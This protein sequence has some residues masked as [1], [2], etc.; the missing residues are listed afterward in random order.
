MM[1]VSEEIEVPKIPSISECGVCPATSITHPARAVFTEAGVLIGTFG[2]FTQCL[3]G[4]T[5]CEA[6]YEKYVNPQKEPQKED[7]KQEEPPK[8]AKK[9][10]LAAR[11]SERPRDDKKADRS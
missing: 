1:S 10:K 9:P 11:K 3:D 6:C 2:Q 7:A 4:K 5:R 8:S